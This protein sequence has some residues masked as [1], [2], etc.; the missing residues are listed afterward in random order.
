MIAL[1]SSP[2]ADAPIAG[3]AA[4]TVP[5]PSDDRY[6]AEAVARAFAAEASGRGFNAAATGRRFTGES[7]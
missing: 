7:S 5:L 6:I 2:M 3:G 4:I 1:G